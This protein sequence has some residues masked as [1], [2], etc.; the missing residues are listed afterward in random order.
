HPSFGD[1]K[2]YQMDPG[3]VKEAIREA[4]L[5]VAEGADMVMVKPAILY[6]DVIRAVS[7]C[8]NVPVAAY[9][10]SGEYAML[11][12]AAAKGWVDEKSAA[13]EMLT[14]MKR[15]GASVLITYWAKEASEWLKG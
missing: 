13:L 2:S 15:A 1:R 12:A 3:N 11:K 7:G 4:Q 9:N 6:L 10:V 5:D 14:A 8:V